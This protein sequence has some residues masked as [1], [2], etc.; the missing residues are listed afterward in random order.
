M[1]VN[2]EDIK[3][4]FQHDQFARHSNIELLTAAPGHSTAKMTLHP[5]HLNGLKTVHGGA[6][7]TLA[8]FAFAVACNS[9]GTMAVALDVSIV[10]MKAATTGTLWAEAREV[11]KNFKVGLY[12]V[13]IKDD[14]GDLV[15]QFQGLAYRKKEKLP[16]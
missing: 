14:H 3:R 16:I 5:H 4:C 6:I 15:A 13:D 11:S 8:D 12:M 2:M 1:N 10:F 9:H 7:F